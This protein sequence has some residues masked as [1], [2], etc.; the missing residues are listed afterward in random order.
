MEYPPVPHG[1]GF[2]IPGAVPN[3][4]SSRQKKVFS[5]RLTNNNFKR[6]FF[7]PLREILNLKHTLFRYGGMTYRFS[8]INNQFVRKFFL[9]V[10]VTLKKHELIG[11]HA[12]GDR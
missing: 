6:L 8:G 11:R 2:L 10:K 1:S 3:A 12:I 5:N 4:K 9:S 7:Y